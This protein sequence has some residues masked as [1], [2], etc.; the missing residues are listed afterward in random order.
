[1]QDLNE[2]E[3]FIELN[4][5]EISDIINE[6]FVFKF[7]E[8]VYISEIEISDYEKNIDDI[9]VETYGHRLD[10]V[11]GKCPEFCYIF[12]K[13]DFITCLNEVLANREEAT[14]YKITNICH[15]DTISKN[16]LKIGFSV[17]KECKEEKQH[18]LVPKPE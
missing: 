1:M 8:Q 2:V 7:K 9:H 17:C 6:Y 18:V 4:P 12:G 14:T 13:D 16:E 11:F 5:K 3:C 15:V 10:K